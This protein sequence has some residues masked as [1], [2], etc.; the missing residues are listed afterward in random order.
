M[1]EP[2]FAI[3]QP[4]ILRNGKTVWYLHTDIEDVSRQK[5]KMVARGAA[6]NED[7]YPTIVCLGTYNEIIRGKGSLRVTSKPKRADPN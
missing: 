5:G 2:L 1:S 6:A 4:Y 3:C 7:A